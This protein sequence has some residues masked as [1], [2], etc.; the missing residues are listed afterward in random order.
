MEA[1]A[2]KMPQGRKCILVKL[3]VYKRAENGAVGGS[4]FV[5]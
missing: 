4:A 2:Q 1:Y 5:L 3:Y